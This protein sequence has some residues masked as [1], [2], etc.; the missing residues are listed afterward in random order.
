MKNNPVQAPDA[1]MMVRPIKFGY[2]VETAS[3]NSFQLNDLSLQEMEIQQNALNEFNV[4][5]E[6]LRKHDIEVVVFDDTPEPH[7]PDSVFPNNWISFHHDGTVVLYPMHAKNRRLERRGEFLLELQKKHHFDI[8]QILDFTKHEENGKFLE[9]TGSIVF[10]YKNNIAYANT[11]PRTNPELLEILSTELGCKVIQFDAHD[12]KGDPIYHTN[13]VMCIGEGF[14]VVCTSCIPD[15][16]EKNQL[17]KSLKDTGHEI[18]DISIDQLS[19]FAGNMIEVKNKDG[20]PFLILS[21]TANNS[22]MPEQINV[23]KKYATLLPIKITTIET[24][25]GGSVRCMLAG[26]FLP[27]LEAKQT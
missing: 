16:N 12:R 3:T 14:A 17:I 6:T 15:K 19:M 24:Y 25:G 22:L 9:G 10:D 5:V 20:Q 21:E 11:S 2:N 27:K 13:V 8:R 7:T 1:L 4:F 23:L 18:V 26:I